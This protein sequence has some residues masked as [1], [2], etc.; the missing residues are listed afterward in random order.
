VEG[1]TDRHTEAVER[2]M[3]ALRRSQSRRTLAR[4]AAR[5]HGSQA[6]GPAAAAYDVLDVIEAGEEAGRAATVTSVAAVLN[7]DQPRASKLAAG[8]CWCARQQDGA[9]R[10]RCMPSAGRSSPRH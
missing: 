4:L 10:R 3:V 6:D 8:P 2:A 9:R 5:R 1:N 7:I